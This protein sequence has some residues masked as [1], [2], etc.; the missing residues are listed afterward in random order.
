M[1][2][3][4]IV[5]ILIVAL[6]LLAGCGVTTTISSGGVT[7]KL[8]QALA[9]INQPLTQLA[10]VGENTTVGEVK[11]MQQKLTTALGVLTKLPG[12]DGSAVSD[13]QNANDELT[14]MIKDKPDNA[15]LGEVSPR[16]QDFKTKVAKAQT[17]VSKL[18]STLKCG[19]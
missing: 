15:T 17:S 4:R 5:L 9:S 10:N 1:R 14:A 6:T 12:G 19:S 18:S 2:R 11:A 3:S 13:I 7:S 16:L 8:C